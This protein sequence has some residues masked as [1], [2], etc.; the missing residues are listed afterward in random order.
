MSVWGSRGL[1]KD[2]SYIRFVGE[3]VWVPRQVRVPLRAEPSHRSEQVSELLWGE[4]QQILDEM[5]GWLYVRG[6]MDGYAG[7]VVAGSLMPAWKGS[8]G[9]AVVAYPYAPLYAD[10]RR[11][12]QVPIGSLWPSDGIWQTATRIYTTQVKALWLWPN[13]SQDLPLRQVYRAFRGTPYMW[14]GKS[15][16]GIDCS[17]LVQIAYR[18]SGFLLPRDAY[19][20]AERAFPTSVPKQGDLVFFTAQPGEGRV[21]HVGL[22]MGQDRI[23]HAAPSAGVHAISLHALFTHAFHS[24]RAPI[25]K[26][27]VI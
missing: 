23:L 3:W 9:W 2:I 26:D 1:R 6:W 12:G 15:P 4:P 16:A 5:K 20:Q 13:A 19:Q 21:T 22:Y 18:L 25:H 14:G 8:E 10:G 24:F 11:I 7:W 17:G 27:F